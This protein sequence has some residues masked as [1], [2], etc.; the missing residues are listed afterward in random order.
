M[1]EAM[2][3]SPVTISLYVKL[4]C[5]NCDSKWADV[6]INLMF[7]LQKVSLMSPDPV[8][9]PAWLAMSGEGDVLLSAR[10]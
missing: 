1:E 2:Q 10:Q 3:I 4:A 8:L 6:K 7:Y 5:K 9:Q